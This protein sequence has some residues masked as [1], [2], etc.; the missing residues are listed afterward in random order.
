ML[1]TGQWYHVAFVFSYAN[2]IMK[3][4]ID[5]KEVGSKTTGTST[6]DPTVM[7]FNKSYI[8]GA[9][10]GSGTETNYVGLM[11]N[12]RIY[13]KVLTPDQIYTDFYKK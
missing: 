11:D 2:Q 8:G 12:F 9:A 6:P 13:D 7:T 5:G 4:Y 3:I 1:K 10:F